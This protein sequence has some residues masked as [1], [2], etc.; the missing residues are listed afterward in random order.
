MGRMSDVHSFIT[1][2]QMF[3]TIMNCS[4]IKMVHAAL[5]L[6]ERVWITGLLGDEMRLGPRL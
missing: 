3:A 1:S 6:E 4:S 2:N 5:L